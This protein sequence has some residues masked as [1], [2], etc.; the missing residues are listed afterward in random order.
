MRINE[1]MFCDIR[2]RSYAF[3]ANSGKFLWQTLL[4]DMGKTLDK[5]FK[6]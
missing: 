1:V 6:H 3:L 4:R 2:S 5:L